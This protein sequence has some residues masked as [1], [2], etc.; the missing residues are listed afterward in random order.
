[1]QELPPYKRLNRS[2]RAFAGPKNVYL[3]K[4]PD[5]L[6]TIVVHIEATSS[7]ESTD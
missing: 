2:R 4:L 6:K 3:A 1:M 7:I 5:M